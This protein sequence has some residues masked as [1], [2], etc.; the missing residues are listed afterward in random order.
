[1]LLDILLDP[2]TENL[3][4][5]L[6]LIPALLMSLSFHECGH[7]FAAYKQGDGFARFSGRMTL[8]PL[9]HIDPVGFLCLLLA[10]FG[11]AKPVPI[12]PNNFKHGKKSMIIVSLAGIIANILLAF[13]AFNVLYFIA[14]IA[15]A[16][17]SLIMNAVFSM[18]YYLIIINLSLAVFNLIPIPPLDGYK[19]AREFFFSWKNRS[20]FDQIERYSTFILIAFILAISRTGILSVITGALYTGMANM[21]DFIYQ[22]F[23]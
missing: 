17:D 4:A 1:M 12:V 18:L 19:V 11:W 14:Y 15:K 22:A 7:A 2:T 23:I 6:L 8:N 16:K 10:G 5:F 20:F 3:L 9:K 21:C 13:F